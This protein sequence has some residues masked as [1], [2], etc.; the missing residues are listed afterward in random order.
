MNAFASSASKA[1]L[2]TIQ[3]FDLE[4]LDFN[5]LKGFNVLTNI[6]INQCINTP[7][8]GNPPKNLPTLPS[9]ISILIDGTIY[10]NPCFNAALL[11][12]CTCWVPAG[13]KITSITCPAG[14]T[15]A[16]IQNAFKTLPSDANIGNVVLNIPYGENT[17]PANLLGDIAA[18]TIELI[19]PVISNSLLKLTVSKNNGKLSN[20]F[21]E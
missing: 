6:F 15:F 10:T 3:A 4:I 12:P 17:I 2:F 16:E 5:F 8:I 21:I 19:G 11:A 18:D 14:T 13:A 9:L 7:T 20:Y 1:R